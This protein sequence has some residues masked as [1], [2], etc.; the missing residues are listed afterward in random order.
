[1]NLE[2]NT[3][4]YR[5]LKDLEHATFAIT[6]GMM[7]DQWVSSSL[8]EARFAYYRTVFDCLSALK[9]GEVDAFP[10]DEAVLTYLAANLLDSYAILSDEKLEAADY[11]FAVSLSRPDL[12]QAMDET[13]A[14]IKANGIYEEMLDRWFPKAGALGIRPDIKLNGKN[15]TLRFGTSAVDRPFTFVVGDHVITGFDVEL[16]R[17]ICSKL[18]MDLEIRD[19]VF[20]ELI[21]AL[22][23]GKVDM[24]GSGITITQDRSEKVLFSAPY[25][26][27]RIAVLVKK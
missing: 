8:P 13:I 20:S 16:A 5:S 9:E 12:K 26:H 22:V 14:E 27:G 23:S 4:K 11:G 18:E 15:G 24:I 7:F 6:E 10:Y 3:M 19:M 25:F 2:E 21:P 1:M 17:R